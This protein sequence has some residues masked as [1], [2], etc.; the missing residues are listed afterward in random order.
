MF[1]CVYTAEISELFMICSCV[2]R[3]VKNWFRKR[4]SMK[5]EEEGSNRKQ[6]EQDLDLTEQP[7]LGLFGEYLEMGRITSFVCHL[8]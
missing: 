6:W 3:M 4:K 8:H 2:D 7:P 5:K 1:S